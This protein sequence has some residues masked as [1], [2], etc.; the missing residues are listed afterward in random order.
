MNTEKKLY[1]WDTGQK[2]TG[3]TGLYV[4]FPINNEVYR[5]ETADGTCIIPDELLQTS[6]GHKV[7][8]CMTNNTIRSFAFSVTPRPKPSDY[9]YT[10]T[11]RL[12]FEGL[13]QKVD[14]A[15]A[16]M[17]RRAESGEFDGHTPVK[18]T[19]YFTTAEIQQIQNEVSS[20]AIGEFK[21]TVDTETDKFNANATEKVNAYNQNDSEKTASYNANATKKLNA[22]NANANNRV[23]EFDSH[24]EQIQTDISELKSDLI[25]IADK[26]TVDFSDSVDGFINSS[27]TFVSGNG[28]KTS[29]PF[30]LKKM[31]TLV[32][33]SR[34]Y[35][36]DGSYVSIIS[37]YDGSKYTPLVESISSKTETYTY[38]AN[39]DIQLVICYDNVITPSGD[40]FIHLETL[41]NEKADNEEFQKIKT[42]IE[43]A[44]ET[45]EITVTSYTDGYINETGKFTSGG[46][47]R[48]S[49]PIDVSNGMHISVSSR[50]YHNP[51]AFT[52]AIISEYV[53]GEYKPLVLSR[54]S[55]TEVYE[56][57][58]PK[59]MR[60]VVCY[61]NVIIPT[62]TAVR[63][64][65]NVYDVINSVSKDVSD[66]YDYADF[67][68]EQ[69]KRRVLKAEKG[70]DFAWAEFDK[71]YFIFVHDDT[72]EYLEGY[73]E[74]FRNANVPMSASTIPNAL[75]ETHINTLKSMVENGGEVLAHFDGSIY[76]TS[77]D[78]EWLSI[79]RDG[80][81]TL[82][83]HG[84]EV[85]G[86]TN[87][88]SSD[89]GS[90]KGEKYC[91]RYFDYAIT[92][93]G[94]SEQYKLPR[95]LMLGFTSLESFKAQIDADANVNGIHAYGFHGGR[96]DESW[97]T[98]EAMTEIIAY[99]KS[100]GNCE[101]TTYSRLFD[102]FGSTVLLERIKLLENN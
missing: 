54:S 64:L 2:L 22:Y 74:V 78:N 26:S 18:G 21:S 63:S 8:E 31:H 68:L 30:T 58:C 19:D 12:T 99:I 29:K 83:S 91:R 85:R 3:C 97:I 89:R 20:G 53:N 84:F 37:S 32:A 13:V 57:D 100:K 96:E 46:G 69:L 45:K 66:N 62:G 51:T 81:R 88:G 95:T 34:G 44:E 77:S 39:E 23:A 101:F 40:I 28:Y 43:S 33:K 80:K 65:S 36:N 55:K 75:N 73:E 98:N 76:Q 25:R 15:V 87:A 71:P 61:D 7:Y 86:I 11:E 1:Q 70:N 50:G 6:G 41:I 27:G 14:D 10:S 59:D 102:E 79:T 16:D 5:V 82:E 42:D 38:T 24:T 92:S 4:D 60:I 47:Y 35:Y 49:Q 94:K 17:I 48:V 67:E 93:V 72:N 9:V 90:E 56:Y 52:V